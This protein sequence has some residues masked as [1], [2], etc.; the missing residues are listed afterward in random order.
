MHNRFLIEGGNDII[1]SLLQ[2][3][4]ESWMRGEMPRIWKNADII[5]IPKHGGSSK[6]EKMRP[7]SLLSVVGKLM[8]KLVARR[9]SDRGERE[10]WFPSWQ[11]G[12]R[13]GRGVCDQLVAFSHTVTDAWRCRQKCIT[14][15]LDASKA[16]D[17]VHR[18]GLI[19]KLI[20]LGLRGRMLRWI[21]DFI[22]ERFGRVRIDGEHSRYREY[23]YGLPQG[24][25]LS[26]ILFNVFFSDMFPAEISDPNIRVGVYA[27]DICVTVVGETTEQVARKLSEQLELV[28][29]WGRKNRVRFDKLSDKCGYMIFSRKRTSDVDVRFGEE[30]LKRKSSHKY[31]G[32]IFEENFSFSKHLARV[33]AK[34]WSAYHLVRRVVGERW[35]ATTKAV[36]RLYE[37]LI[38]PILEAACVVWDGATAAEKVTLERVHRLSLMAATGASN[39]TSTQEL[40]IY[41]NTQSLQDRRDYIVASYFNRVQRLDPETHPVASA[42]RSWRRAGSPPF[43]SRA[44]FFPRAAALCRRLCRFSEFDEGSPDF[45]EPIPSPPIRKERSRQWR[46]NDK[47]HGK[48]AHIKLLNCLDPNNDIVIYTDGSACPNPGRIGL[49]VCGTIYGK[50]QTYGQPIGI[51]S[52]ITA[53]LCAIL[54]ALKKTLLTR[55]LRLFNRV[56]IFSDCQSAIDLSL[57]RCTPTHS[58]Q[59]VSN[60]HRALRALRRIISV[61]ILWVP[62]HVG[63]P[64]NE[65]ANAAAKNAAIE[66]KDGT[67]V[68]GQPLITLSTSRALIKHAQKEKLQ[69]QWLSVVYEKRGTEHL[70]RLRPD[71][72]RP[73]SFFVGTRQQQTILARLRFGSCE[74]HAS[75]SRWYPNVSELCECGQIETVRHFLLHCEKYRQSRTKMISEIRTFWQG[76]ISED[77][78]LGGATVRLQDC[79]WE[80]VVA[81]VARFVESTNRKI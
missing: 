20:N 1:L 21:M 80:L 7:I 59:L 28:E 18:M 19:K 55:N 31:L 12:F 36:V 67:A 74:L 70:S 14:A 50:T 61:T 62:A 45:L 6:I 9:L 39:R 38:R 69:K 35:G 64:G 33:K 63:V 56:F 8:D 44:S 51:G 17:R 54:S 3:F 58:F 29:R 26:P 42:L 53:E 41:C 34:A 72:S 71:V 78:L 15:F 49:G 13:P 24:S 77:L 10:G 23:R 52:N 48:L 47:D 68:P 30:S 32:V 46:S 66:V 79:Q 5:A 57:E 27:D 73:S 22:S 65:A 75:R 60:I 40:E 76:I 81:A 11:G 43:H 37:G 25:C 4:N 16:Y 2:L